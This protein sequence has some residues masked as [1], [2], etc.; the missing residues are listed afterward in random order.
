MH[1]DSRN[2][3]EDVDALYLNNIGNTYLFKGDYDNARSYFEQ[4]LQ[5]R[6]KINVPGDIATTLHNLAEV[7]TK[8]GQYEQAL[9]QYMRALDLY[10]NAGDKQ[11]TAIESYSLG[12]IFEDQGRYGSAES[13]KKQALQNFREVKENSFWMGEALSGYGNALSEIGRFDEGAKTLARGARL[14]PPT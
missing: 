3:N 5:L 9:S 4:A 13:S 10:R 6:E 12:T 8:S 11:G 14:L 2:Q 7:N 1:R